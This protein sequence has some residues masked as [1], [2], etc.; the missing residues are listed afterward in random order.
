MARHLPSRL[1]SSGVVVLLSLLTVLLPS[2]ATAQQDWPL[3]CHFRTSQISFGAHGF[4]VSFRGA[5]TAAR[6]KAPAV[7]ECAWEDRGW[8]SDEPTML[9]FRTEGEYATL[10][11][12]DGQLMSLVAVNSNPPEAERRAMVLVAQ[13]WR[14]AGTITFYVVNE[15]RVMR[16]TR[17]AG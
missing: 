17:I 11:G 7:G 13:A 10:L 9:S 14:G 1:T 8:R 5:A 2:S 16:I 3:R 12:P 6:T 4:Q 15:G